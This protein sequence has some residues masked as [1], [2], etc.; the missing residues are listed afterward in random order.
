MKKRLFIW[1]LMINVM[2]VFGI[3]HGYAQEQ[4]AIDIKYRK[5]GGGQFIYCNNPEFISPTQVS[6]YENPE[7]T[8]MM[9]NEGLR[10]DNYSVFFCFYNWT[11]FSM[12]PDIEFKSADDAEIRIDSIGFY[13]PQAG[14]YWDCLGAWA[15]LMKIDIRPMNNSEQ[16][17]HYQGKKIFPVTIKLSESNDWISRYIYNYETLLPCVTFNMLVNFTIVSGEVDVNFTALKH[18]D[19]LGDRSMH[20]PNAK[21]GTYVR[22]TAIKGIDTQTLPIVETDFNIKI[23]KDTPNGE[24]LD[25]RVFNQFHPDGIV[26]PYWVSNINPS[27]D[28]SIFSKNTA[29]GSDM[30]NFTYKDDSKLNYYGKNVPMSERDNIWKMDIYHYDTQTYNSWMPWSAGNHIP[31][32]FTYLIHDDIYDLPDHNLQFNLGNF[33]VTNRHHLTI[34]NSDSVERTLNYIIESA[35]S[36]NIVI[37]RDEYG[38]MLN[39]YTLK[40]KDAFALSKEIKW[41]KREE[42]CMF[43]ASVPPGKTKK[44]I[45]DVILPTNTYGGQLNIL[46]ADNHKYLVEK[47]SS[48]FSKYTQTNEFKTVFFDGEAYMKWENGALKR[49]S[50]D[51][52]QWEVIDLPEQTREIFAKESYEISMVKTDHGYAAR[53][54]GWD[55]FNGIIEKRKEKT[56]LHLLDEAFNYLQ[57]YKFSDYILG[58][59]FADHRLYVKSDANYRSS[60]DT[61]TKFTPFDGNFPEF[62]GQFEVVRKNNQFYTPGINGAEARIA[63][64][65]DVPFNLRSTKGLFY[66]FKSWQSYVTSVAA[67]NIL[68]ISTDCL[69]WVDIVLPK[70]F[71]E[72]PKVY[73]IG[74]KIYVAT[75]YETFV[76]N[77]PPENTVRVMLNREFLSFNTPAN[78]VCDRTMVPIRFFFEK[79]GANVHWHDDS[80]KITITK[81]GRNV[82]IQ[83][84]STHATVDGNEMEMDVAP[85]IE[86]GKTMIP[87]RFLSEYLGCSVD[88]EEETKTASVIAV[89]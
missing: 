52:N 38:R 66:Y 81:G 5:A 27:R 80:S 37:V 84:D 61:Y 62:S 87:L 2:L 57:S 72:L 54:S 83:I 41:D 3:T 23:D 64:E 46:R 10:P 39:P 6:T 71:L 58:L 13:T 19:V 68:S 25:V 8:Y 59:T 28:T 86:N 78:V 70:R 18:Y 26:V 7:A 31:N 82:D 40:T 33:G 55:R 1:T 85:Y 60:D 44:Y 67:E 17:V 16:Y 36:S 50:D 76:Y 56:T 79:L 51:T 53:Y 15:D 88:W 21:R 9:N 69:N 43:S 29:V 74:G 30:L 4:K 12:E 45:L 75:K 65:Q 32:A 47:P 14:E 22:D 24:N 20:N 77:A 34:T 48:S 73:Y 89:Y 42:V 63:F 49:F 11:D 35:I